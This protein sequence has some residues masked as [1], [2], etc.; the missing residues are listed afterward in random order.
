MLLVCPY[1]QI[2]N[3]Q[4]LGRKNKHEMLKTDRQALLDDTVKTVCVGSNILDNPCGGPTVCHRSGP[5]L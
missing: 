4:G 3:W 5:V 1:G 2:S